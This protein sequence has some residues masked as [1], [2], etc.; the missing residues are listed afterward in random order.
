MLGCCCCVVVV[1]VVVESILTDF[2][3]RT[4]EEQAFMRIVKKIIAPKKLI[5]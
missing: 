5:N 1:V 3:T 4:I 2:L